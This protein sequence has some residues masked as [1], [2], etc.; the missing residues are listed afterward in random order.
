MRGMITSV[1]LG[2]A[3]GIWFIYC[4]SRL[5]SARRALAA[6]WMN[7]AARLGAV[8]IGWAAC[9]LIIIA[10]SAAMHAAGSR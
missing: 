5:Y 4:I 8:V 2:P 6:A 9:F 10:V 3:I 1:W 7:Q